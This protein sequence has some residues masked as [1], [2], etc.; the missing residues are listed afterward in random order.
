MHTPP[1]AFMVLAYPRSGTTWLANWLTT[2][3]SLCLH[4]PLAYGLPETWPVDQRV[5]GI[6]CTGSYLL[7]DWLDH[8]RCPIAVIE[9]DRRACDAS[10]GVLGLPAPGDMGTAALDAV[11]GRRFPFAA[12]WDEAEAAKLWAYLLPQF[13]F[14]AIRYRLL[15][16]MQV[17]PTR[18]SIDASI[19]SALQENV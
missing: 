5:R 4:D 1:L 14:D 18:R 7:P 19:L 17:Q 9:R 3:R 13:P 2:D 12:L 11:N 8:Y 15:R 10:M 6:S 16:D